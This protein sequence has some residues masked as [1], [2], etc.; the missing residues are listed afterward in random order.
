MRSADAIDWR[1]SFANDQTELYAGCETCK[2]VAKHIDIAI[3]QNVVQGEMIMS[4]GRNSKKKSHN[5][6]P[7]TVKQKKQAKKEKKEKKENRGVFDS[8]A[9][10]QILQT[11]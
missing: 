8:Q 5:R 7:K 2:N 9:Q 6:P 11:H 1:V 10:G 4:K 3:E